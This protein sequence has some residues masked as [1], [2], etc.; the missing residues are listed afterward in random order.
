[1][2]YPYNGRLA[3]AVGG[4]LGGLPRRE[5]G[6]SSSAGEFNFKLKTQC[7]A[8]EII[9]SISNGE[10]F[11]SGDYTAS[12]FQT[13]KTVSNITGNFK[14][15]Q[16]T[17]IETVGS[18]Y[19][20]VSGLNDG[21][22]VVTYTGSASSSYPRFARYNASGVLQGSITTIETVVGLA[23]TS[24]SGLNDGGFVVTYTGSASSYP[25]FCKHI[26]LTNETVTMVGIT[27]EASSNIENNV[28]GFKV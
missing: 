26:T 5:R 23:Y 19:T 21:G 28:K 20:S 25:K 11:C 7:V 3:P 1:M 16:L 10:N 17:T 8:G 18:A 22:F 13:S 14:V 4:G 12:R 15:N 24:V 9:F 27:V 2:S 6:S